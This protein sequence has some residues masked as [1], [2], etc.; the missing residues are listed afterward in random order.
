MENSREL[1]SK[2]KKKEK[3]EKKRKKR[4]FNNSTSDIHLKKKDYFKKTYMNT[5]AHRR[6]FYDSQNI[7]AT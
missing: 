4:K 5:D 3:K 2:A 7:K 6:I 1:L